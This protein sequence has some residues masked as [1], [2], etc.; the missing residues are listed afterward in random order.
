MVCYAKGVS[1]LS[2][3]LRSYPRFCIPLHVTP[4]AK[5]L[6]HGWLTALPQ[7]T[8]NDFRPRLTLC[9]HG[10]FAVRSYR[11]PKLLDLIVGN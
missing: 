4:T 1:Y 7:R 5:R 11:T 2:L 9:D 10:N 6:R 3:E 8:A